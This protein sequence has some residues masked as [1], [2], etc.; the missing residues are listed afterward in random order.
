MRNL[1][2]VFH[3]AT[4]IYIPTNSVFRPTEG[5]VFSILFPILLISCFLLIAILTGVKENLTVALVCISLIISDTEHFFLCLLAIS[6]SSLGKRLIRASALFGF[7]CY[8]VVWVLGIFWI[9][10]HY[11]IHNLQLFPSI[12]LVAFSFCW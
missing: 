7:F 10:T 8:W 4:P 2:I 3:N 1:H 5:S 12:Q 6:I 11:K 9:L